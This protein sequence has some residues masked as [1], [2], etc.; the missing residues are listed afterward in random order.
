MRFPRQ[1]PFHVLIWL[2]QM[3]R[4]F[5]EPANVREYCAKVWKEILWLIAKYR[6]SVSSEN[7]MFSRQCL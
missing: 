5:S 2:S 3:H 6:P 7:F 4:V 1:I